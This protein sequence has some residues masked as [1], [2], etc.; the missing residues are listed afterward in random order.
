MA[1]TLLANFLPPLLATSL[2]RHLQMDRIFVLVSNDTSD[3]DAA[4]LASMT[5]SEEMSCYLW[6]GEDVFGEAFQEMFRGAIIIDAMGFHKSVESDETWFGSDIA[7]MVDEIYCDVSSGLRLDSQFYSIKPGEPYV[8]KEVYAVRSKLFE[9][10]LGTWDQFG[11]LKI[12]IPYIWD[13]RRDLSGAT[14]RAASLPWKGFSLR[15]NDTNFSGYVPDLLSAIS[16]VYNFSVAWMVPAD[17]NYGAALEN[18]SFNGLTGLLQRGEADI[19]AAGFA[20]TLGRSR[21]ISY[22]NTVFRSLGTLIIID[23]AYI[24]MAAEINADAYFAIFTPLGWL[25]LWAALFCIAASYFIFFCVATGIIG[26]ISG[27]IGT[28]K[29]ALF[30]F[31]SQFHF[32][33]SNDFPQYSYSSKMFYFIAAGYSIVFVAYYEGILTSYLTVTSPPHKFSSISDVVDEGNKVITIAESKYETDFNSA[34]PGTGRHKAYE[35]TMKN[36]PNAFYPTVESMT[37]AI[38]SNPTSF[39]V[40]GIEHTFIGDPRFLPL[41]GLVDAREDS[42]AF[43]VQKNSEFVNLINYQLLKM[44]SSGLEPFLRNKWLE[45]REP[46][47]VCGCNVQDEAQVLG[48]KNLLFPVSILFSGIVAGLVLMILESL[49]KSLWPTPPIIYKYTP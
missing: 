1:A 48:I 28:W 34:P 49:L 2:A 6:T 40:A 23:P 31:H 12:P 33:I 9:K 14:V 46:E 41:T 25:C 24:G 5:L 27:L 37:E 29:A 16:K 39:A 17:G 43:G 45:F 32:P 13:R 30:T 3:G 38:L 22:S 15:V 7:W 26:P 21:A 11:G 44:E 35:Q 20:V 4:T 10:E 8:L 19:V 47:D 36:N 18:G 42:I